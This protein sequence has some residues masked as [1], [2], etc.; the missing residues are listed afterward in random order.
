MSPAPHKLTFFSEPGSSRS[1]AFGILSSL[2]YAMSVLLLQPG[3]K[4][5]HHRMESQPKL[6]IAEAQ[7]S[8]EG[9][10]VLGLF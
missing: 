10:V 2:S 1:D 3:G 5:G 7:G 6:N 8:F 9:S 4:T